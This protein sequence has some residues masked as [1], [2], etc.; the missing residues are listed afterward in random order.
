MKPRPILSQGGQCSFCT[1][2][3]PHLHAP[4]ALLPEWVPPRG[5]LLQNSGVTL[6]YFL[7]LTWIQMECSPSFHL[8]FFF[9]HTH[10]KK[11]CLHYAAYLIFLQHSVQMKTYNH[12]L[13]FS[14]SVFSGLLFVDI[15]P[16]I[17]AG[18]GEVRTLEYCLRM[19]VPLS[20][21]ILLG[22]VQK[23]Q[24]HVRKP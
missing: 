1:C 7:T 8:F 16:E 9:R 15:A 24:T 12:H 2:S 18:E 21:T 6:E 17:L 3:V 10:Q 13:L 20:L 14:L 23:I 4:G 5:A 19:S 22:S 11:M